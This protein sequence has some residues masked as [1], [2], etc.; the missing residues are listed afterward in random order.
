MLIDNEKSKYKLHEYIT[1]SIDEGSLDAVTGYF[2]VG[3]L[4][5]LSEKINDRI[6]KYRFI[7]GDFVSKEATQEHGVDLLNENLTAEGAF[8]IAE[9]AKRAVAFLEQ[10]VVEVKTLEP[11]F[12]HA[13]AYIFNDKKGDERHSFYITG[14]SNLT[15]AG[16]GL[17][18]NNNAELNIAGTAMDS[19][20]NEIVKWFKGIWDSPKAKTEIDIL[21]PLTNKK[22]K[23][24][25][26]TYLIEEI[27]KVFK[28]YTPK[29]IY[30]KILFELFGAEILLEQE[31]K[32]FNKEMGK[33][34]NTRVYQ[35][36][37]PFQQRGVHALIKMLLKYNGAILGDAV[38]LGKTWS[39][40]A[41]MKY[42]EMKGHKTVVL[43]PKKLQQNWEK[44]LEDGN[45]FSADDYKYK[46]RF[47]TDLQD[48]RWNND[49]YTGSQKFDKEDF[50]NDE[51]KLLV[52]DESHNLRNDKSGRYQLLVNE[53]LVKTKGDV[54]VLMLSATPINNS[55][56]DIRNQ[57]RLITRGNDNG[58]YDSIGIK[59]IDYVFRRAQKEFNLW[60]ALPDPRIG[61]FIKMLPSEFFRLTDSLVVSRTRKMIKGMHNDLEFP[62]VNKPDNVFVTPA[63]IGN[64]ESFDELYNHF[65]PKLSGYQ[66]SNYIEQKKDSV[67]KDEQQRDFFLVKMMYILMVKRLESSWYSFYVTSGRIL[68]HHQNALNRIRQY[69]K[70]KAD[71][72]ENSNIEDMVEEDDEL[73]QEL[74]HLTL[75]KKRLTKLSD[76]DK[77][78]RLEDYKKDL[79]YDIEKLQF[80]VNNLAAFEHSITAEE[81]IRGN[82][83]SKD[84]KL[85][86]L[87]Q[88]I[89][90]KRR[91]GAN[92]GN[93]K[94][95]IFTAYKD[96]GEYLFRQLQ[97]RGFDKLAF[98]S[99]DYSRT[100]YTEHTI[101]KYEPILQQFA[102]YTKLYGEKEWAF[103]PSS[104][105]LSEY[106]K[107]TEWQ[108]WLQ[109]HHPSYY[110][111]LTNPIDILIAT[112]ALS[113]GQNLQDSDLVI[114]Y[115]IHWNPVRIIQRMG[116]IDRLGSLNT[117]IFGINFWPSKN[118]NTY[119]NLQ[120]RIEQR[121][122][123]MKLAGS[124][125]NHQFSDSFKEMAEDSSLEQ[126][127]KEKMLK[128][129]E[130]TLDDIEEG[131]ENLGM[132][133]L[134]LEKYR[135]LLY[136]EL[137]KSKEVYQNMPKGVYTGFTNGKGDM[138]KEGL[139]ALLGYPARKANTKE[140]TYKEFELIYINE[141]GNQILNNQKEVLEGLTENLNQPRFVPDK[142]D[143]GD[144]QEMQ[145]LSTAVKHWL[146]KQAYEEEEDE[147]GSKKRK[148]GAE[149][150]DIFQKL[151]HGDKKA[152][153]K[154]KSGEKISDK[155]KPENYDLIA[156]YVITV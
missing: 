153:E 92:E 109:V 93:Q 119:L 77:A 41:V 62:K 44:F 112:D 36:L 140:H 16:I 15:E 30:Y 139:V 34:E 94:V 125:V 71:I 126:K 114:N 81:S 98:V 123:A 10:D 118:I 120:G 54:K 45:I 67:L 128:Q 13:K 96:T 143:K 111:K 37:Y 86:V 43:C 154:V 69:Q 76:I 124:E 29:D 6:D 26:K 7:L 101:R 39:A 97:K 87:I 99:G 89:H 83:L 65:P 46:I 51:P 152:F 21:N 20:H 84:S 31:D 2:T 148:M 149:G 59:N 64:V 32:E 121:M 25:F 12:C 18:K 27:Q 146:E 1:N 138:A 61:E 40:L 100:S 113:E 78:G 58:F 116:R 56:L 85:E 133:D 23:K 70:T 28:T 110:E 131:A 72:I 22:E 141:E 115:D 106:Q 88:K 42:F 63:E 104:L 5:F 60:R 105:F 79:K 47:H 3:A 144:A 90:E 33:L 127:Q 132:D 147:D 150:K 122:A 49:R 68:E 130:V 145:K 107:F 155:Y 53:L 73:S 136:E 8:K 108:Q 4:S 82:H 117:E 17:R 48:D 52:I 19:Q 151:K 24:N 57:F 156:W 91:R 137:D 134:S 38:G 50:I 102:P 135:Q 75:G 66:P 80:L 142:I 11:N 35:K 74:E 14:S 95:V 9:T 103:T 129:M 55:L